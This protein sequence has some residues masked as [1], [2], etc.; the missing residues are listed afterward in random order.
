MEQILTEAYA[1]ER[2][3]GRM[4][5]TEMAAVYQRW[6]NVV[7]KA[8]MAYCRNVQD[9]EDITHDVFLKRFQHAA[10]FPED[11]AEK[12]WLLRVTINECKNLLKSFRRKHSVSLEEAEQICV[13]PQEHTVFDA[14]NALPAAYRIA[15]HLFYYEGYSTKEI[16]EI[17]RRSDA[18]VRKQLQRAREMLKTA[19]GEGFEI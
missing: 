15:V 4:E 7:Y 1:G 9:A 5:Q 3:A 13:T 12:A 14:V 2:E 8:A 19:L 16:A 10:A 6:K 11:E 18:A 17:T